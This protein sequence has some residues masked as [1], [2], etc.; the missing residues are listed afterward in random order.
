MIFLDADDLLLPHA[1]ET[2]V[3]VHLSLRVD[4]G[5]TRRATCFRSS[6]ATRSCWVRRPPSTERFAQARERRRTARGRTGTWGAAVAGRMA[7]RK[8]RSHHPRAG[9]LRSPMTSEWVW[10]PTSGNCFRRDALDLF[11]DNPALRRLRTGTDLYFCV[12]VNAISGS[13]LID[14]ALAIYRLHGGNIYSKRPQ[15]ENVLAYQARLL[16]RQQ[17]A[18]EGVAGRPPRRTAP[19]FL[20][21]GWKDF[22]YARLLRRLDC[23]DRTQA[24]RAALGRALALAPISSSASL[25]SL[26]CSGRGAQG[27]DVRQRRSLGA[28][29]DCHGA[30]DRRLS[31]TQ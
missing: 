24:G 16:R 30:D 1:V 26:R 5:F 29:F 13:A 31:L 15:L 7:A 18:G 17:R 28:R 6:P 12:G 4:V 23:P 22:D 21:R 3:F 2:H 9:S 8:L 11:A 20:E 14:D 19:Y 10:S 27:T 25:S